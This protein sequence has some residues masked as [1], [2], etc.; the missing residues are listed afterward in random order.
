MRI[1]GPEDIDEAMALV[2]EF[3]GKTEH[4]KKY[5][6]ETYVRALVETLLTGDKRNHVFIMDEGCFLAGK[7]VPFPYGPTIMAT[8]L[9]WYVREDNR[10]LGLGKDMLEAFEYWAKNVAGASIVNMGSLDESVGEYYI[11]KG[12]TLSERAYIKEV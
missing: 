4:I 1:G 7:A 6:D 5:T 2:M 8:E 11:K 12:Y 3:I 10:G 9:G